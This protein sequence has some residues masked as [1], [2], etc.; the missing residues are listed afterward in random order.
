MRVALVGIFVVWFS[1]TC[2]AGTATA[3]LTVNITIVAGCSVTGN[4]LN[5]GS[6]NVLV[7]NIDQTTTI[8][9]TCTN[10]RPT[11]LA[12]TMAPTARR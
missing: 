3:N 2:Q 11:M 4:T 5:F 12:S 7:A 9:V 10:G 6:Q 1:A 8:S